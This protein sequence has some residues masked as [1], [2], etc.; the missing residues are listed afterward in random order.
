MSQPG[1]ACVDQSAREQYLFTQAQLD[2]SFNA[3]GYNHNAYVQ[4]SPEDAMNFGLQQHYM[5]P[6]SAAITLA[7]TPGFIGYNF[8]HFAT[9][10]PTPGPN[11]PHP[12][13]IEQQQCLDVDSVFRQRLQP[14]RS[15]TNTA[16]LQPSQLALA[17]TWRRSLSQSDIDHTAAINHQALNPVFMR[18]QAPRARS[19]SPGPHARKYHAGRH[20][21]S[22]SQ[23]TSSKGHPSHKDSPTSVPYHVNGLV[24]THIGD[25]IVPDE[26]GFRHRAVQRQWPVQEGIADNI[27]FKHMEPGQMEQ[28]RKIIEI[29]AISVKYR[30]DP[31]LERSGPAMLRTIE[32]VERYLKAGCGEFDGAL[33]GCATI[34]KALTKGE[35]GSCILLGE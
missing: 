15:H 9:G 12:Y 13:P 11:A 10:Y 29:G 33:R 24:P 3:V 32:E 16:H 5:P 17:S 20:T 18:L 34:R 28:S 21:R 6:A 31:A 27:V 30:I 26:S 19:E 4:T 7:P 23:N 2:Q 22:T 8:G 35:N 1:V 14:T 25:P